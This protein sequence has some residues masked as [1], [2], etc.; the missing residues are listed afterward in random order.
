MTSVVK[1]RGASR[2]SAV[3]GGSK[4][5]GAGV[6]MEAIQTVWNLLLLFSILAMPQLLGVLIY[7][8]IRRYHEFG[9]H[10][11]GFLLATVSFFYLA[12]LF[13]VYLPAQT[14]PNEK[15]GM[16]VLGGVFI[17]LFGTFITIVFSLLI[18]SVLR[19]RHH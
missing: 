11:S 14:H 17:V 5:I 1:L 19:H 18:Q 12:S 3:F 9:A 13:W 10:I 7:F 6:D 2:T 8:R 15:C 4:L 16:P